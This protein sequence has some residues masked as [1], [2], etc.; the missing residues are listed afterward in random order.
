MAL[1]LMPLLAK[2]ISLHYV[3]QQGAP[4]PA[5]APSGSAATTASPS[6]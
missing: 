5:A 3:V 6:P 4:A 2:R 1:P